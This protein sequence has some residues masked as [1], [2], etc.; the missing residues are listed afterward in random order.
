MGLKLVRIG[1]KSTPPDGRPYVEF[2]TTSRDPTALRT[3]AAIMAS[4]TFPS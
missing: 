4:A 2:T 3:Y 1:S